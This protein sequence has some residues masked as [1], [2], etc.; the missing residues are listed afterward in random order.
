MIDEHRA[1]ALLSDKEIRRFII[2]LAD[3]APIGTLV[4]FVTPSDGCIT[5]GITVA[6]AYQRRGYA[7]ELL[8]ALT[9][10]LR[11]HFPTLDLIALIHPDNT[12]SVR[13]FE[14]LGFAFDLYAESI[15]SLV[16]ILRASDPCQT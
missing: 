14:G 13:L 8:L 9:H 3:G 11:A 15:H 1:D 2:C 6:P 10:T 4:L 5:L 7:K 12:P 16:Y